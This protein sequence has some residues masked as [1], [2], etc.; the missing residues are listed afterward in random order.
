[1]KLYKVVL[2]IQYIICVVFLENYIPFYYFEVILTIYI[3]K[4]H[5][6]GANVCMCDQLFLVS[7]SSQLFLFSV[8]LIITE[9]EGLFNAKCQLLALQG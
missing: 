4:M 9:G 7:Q 8:S 2:F 1:M 5:F 6:S 3:F